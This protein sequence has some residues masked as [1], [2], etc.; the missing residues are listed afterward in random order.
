[1]YSFMILE[2]WSEIKV[3]VGWFLLE[4]LSEIRSASGAAGKTR[5]HWLETH[6]SN[7][8]LHLCMASSYMCVCVC[9][10]LS[11]FVS[12]CK[13]TSLFSYKDS[14]HWI[15][16]HPIPVRPYLNLTTSVKTLFPSKK[17]S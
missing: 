7:L 10:C 2:A 8:C 3:S 1:M 5:L 17:H 13:S 9:V 16:G 4:A 15:R 12:L 11:A 6:H 14:S